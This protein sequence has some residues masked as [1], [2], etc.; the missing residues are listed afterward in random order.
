MTSIGTFQ[1]ES[2][3]FQAANEEE[4]GIEGAR[5]GPGSGGGRGRGGGK[6]TNV[7]PWNVIEFCSVNMRLK[8]D[9]FS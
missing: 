4:G 7:H 2:L 8:N 6:Y 3:W 9:M 5:E 1:K